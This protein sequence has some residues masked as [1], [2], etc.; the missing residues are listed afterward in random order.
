MG[1]QMKL[2][3]L[4]RPPLPSRREAR[5]LT[6]LDRHWPVARGGG[7]PWSRA[8]AATKTLP[9]SERSLHGEDGGD[10]PGT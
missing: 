4:A 10:A 3:S 9:E 7:H 8:P 5:V 1:K 2:R 6:G